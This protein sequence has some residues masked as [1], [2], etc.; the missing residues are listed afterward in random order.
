[1]STEDRSD[2][3]DDGLRLLIVDHLRR[4]G[5][6]AGRVADSFAKQHAMHP[7]DFQALV[8]VVNAESRGRPATPGSLRQSLNLTSG[9]VTAAIDRL[10]R[11]GHV[12]R[13]PDPADGRIT[14]IRHATAGRTL[15]GEFF[16][17]LGHSTAGVM[18]SF[19]RAE[20]L[21]IEHFMASMTD[22]LAQHRNRV[23]HPSPGEPPSPDE[24]ANPLDQA[25]PV[26]Q[27]PPHPGAPGGV[28]ER[29]ASAGLFGVDPG[30]HPE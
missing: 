3:D 26:E 22:A 19:T 13:E 5:S 27:A 4:Y 16:G 8:V 17:P 30:L 25:Q 1:M 29:R 12:R 21:V 11:S 7:T 14:R 15:A 24:Q 20:L 9:A 28:Q 2:R 23:E 10:V 6:E 18:G